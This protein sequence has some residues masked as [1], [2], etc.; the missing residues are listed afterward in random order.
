[1]ILLSIKFSGVNRI[2]IWSILYN[3]FDVIC[4]SSFVSFTFSF[5][6]IYRY[7]SFKSPGFFC[8]A[9]IC[10]IWSHSFLRLC[11]DFILRSRITIFRATVFLISFFSLFVFNAG[12]SFPTFSLK[13]CYFFVERFGY[14]VSHSKR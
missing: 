11:H 3:F 1:M 2:L 10:C 9:V 6:S 7:I 5:P 14:F 12:M 13:R 4:L 8:G